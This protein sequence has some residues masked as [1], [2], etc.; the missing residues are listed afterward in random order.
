MSMRLPRRWA[1]GPCGSFGSVDRSGFSLGAVTETC[2]PSADTATLRNP[3]G[4]MELDLNA[5]TLL[6]APTCMLSTTVLYFG[7]LGSISILTT[8]EAAT[9]LTRYGLCAAA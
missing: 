7:E 3:E 9:P 6:L 4:A 5:S 2:T 8:Y 1:K